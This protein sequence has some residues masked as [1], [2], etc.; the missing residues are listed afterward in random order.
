MLDIVAEDTPTEN[1]KRLVVMM[2]DIHKCIRQSK[3]SPIAFARRFK[4][5]ACLYMTNCNTGSSARDG[6]LFAML[7]IENA[8]LPDSTT[9]HIILQLVND[10][11]KN[12]SS[13]ISQNVSIPQARLSSIQ[14]HS[15][16][17]TLALQQSPM[18]IAGI[19]SYA[20]EIDHALAQVNEANRA[21]QQENAQIH[22]TLDAAVRAVSEINIS[23]SSDMKLTAANIHPPAVGAMMGT[24]PNFKQSKIR[25]KFSDRK[26]NSTCRACGQKG[27][28]WR[29][30]PACTQEVMERSS[31]QPPSQAKFEYRKRKHP[32]HDSP[33]DSRPNNDRA[34]ISQPQEQHPLPSSKSFFRH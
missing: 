15:D 20:H 19:K 4:G 22:I 8:H 18:D 32:R 7:L 11:T 16:A 5:L 30:R 29:D 2:H 28:W 13:R 21:R 31:G 14:Q 26:A 33:L 27:H 10:T 23:S 24:P 9:N 12:P 3:E 6:Q 25:D 17:L 34:T 1:V